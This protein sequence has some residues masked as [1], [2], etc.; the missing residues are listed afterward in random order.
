MGEDAAHVAVRLSDFR[1][2]AP[3]T[4]P[5]T[6]RSPAGPPEDHPGGPAADGPAGRL[7]GELPPEAVR[8]DVLD[9]IATE[10]DGNRTADQT[11]G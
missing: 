9:A 6:R 11:N 3:L 1:T 7:A 2:S 10:Q 4:T 8:L 5:P